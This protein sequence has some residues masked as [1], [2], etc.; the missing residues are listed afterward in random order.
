MESNFIPKMDALKSTDWRNPELDKKDVK[1]ILLLVLGIAM[2]A[3]VFI[4]W[5][6]LGVKAGDFGAVKLRAFGFD[7]WYG[8]VAAVL[9]IAAIIGA[10]YKHFALTLCSAVMGMLLSFFAFNDYPTSRLNI[11]LA[12]EVEDYLDMASSMGMMGDYDDYDYDDFDDMEGVAMAVNMY[13]DLPSFKLPGQI[14]ELVA[15]GF[16]LVDQRFVYK[17]MKK[18]GIDKE[19]LEE[20]GGVRILNHR[21]GAVLYLVF[22]ILTA[23]MAYLIISGRASSKNARHEA[24]LTDTIFMNR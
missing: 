23:V 4:P 1:K 18:A 17:A 8:I 20:V 22:S 10:L 9:A 14:V 2:L 12:S 24:G 5:F 19:M 13:R 15:V 3:V 11:K 21:L 7:T 6:C 16:D